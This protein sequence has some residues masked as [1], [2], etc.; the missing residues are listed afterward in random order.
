MRPRAFSSADNFLASDV[1]GQ[2]VFITAHGGETVRLSLFGL[3]E[4][5][6]D[7]QFR[8]QRLLVVVEVR[9]VR[10]EPYAVGLASAGRLSSWFH[11]RMTF[12][13][14]IQKSLE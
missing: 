4:Q 10:A 2:T 1:V 12:R 9:V 8:S 6:D 7:T 13:S 3:R 14:A 5:L 11:H